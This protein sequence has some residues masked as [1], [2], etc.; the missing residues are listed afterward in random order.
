MAAL[1]MLAGG[2]STGWRWLC[3]SPRLNASGILKTSMAIPEYLIAILVC[4]A[5]KAPVKPGADG[6]S[7]KC[8]SCRRVY[9]IRDEIPVMLIDE[10]T[11]DPE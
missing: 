2:R 5:C 1:P 6:A 9:P 8:E 7:L 11:I 3:Y 10:A 4:P